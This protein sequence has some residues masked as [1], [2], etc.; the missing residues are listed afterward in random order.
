MHFRSLALAALVGAV[1]AQTQAPMNLTAAAASA[2]LT[3]LASLLNSTG[4]L[5]TLAGLQNITILAPND[6]ALAA[7]TEANASAANDTDLLTAVLQYHVVNGTVTS[8]QIQETPTFVS[9]LL[10]NETFTSLPGGQVVGA[11]SQNGSAYILSGLNNNSTVVTAV[12]LSP[13]LPFLQDA[14]AD[15]DEP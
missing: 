2:N 7:F 15:V 6:E 14:P 5:T 10:T 3:T 11:V 9:T 13:Y 1:N 8:D 12:S 4:L